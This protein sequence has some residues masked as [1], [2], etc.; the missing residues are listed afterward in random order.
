MAPRFTLVFFLVAAGAFGCKKVIGDSCSIASDCS[1]SGDRQCDTTQY[2]GYCT[3]VGC[4]P[5]S[6]PD[7]ASCV[8]FNAHAPRLERRYCMA[9]CETDDDCRT[10]E[11][12]CQ[13]ADARGSEACVNGADGGGVLPPGQSCNVILD[14][15]ARAPGYCVQATQ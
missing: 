7:E 10:P 8:A 13:R 4:D 15:P 2:D 6:C 9:S 11:Y 5:N 12:H 14:T 3:Q 1:I